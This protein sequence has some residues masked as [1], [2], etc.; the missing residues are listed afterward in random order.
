MRPRLRCRLGISGLE[1]PGFLPLGHRSI[2]HSARQVQGSEKEVRGGVAGVGRDRALQHRQRP[3]ALREDVGGGHRGRGVEVR[4]AR[5]ATLLAAVAAVVGDLGMGLRRRRAGLGDDRGPA[6][7]VAG[8]ELHRVVPGAQVHVVDGRLDHPLGIAGEVGPKSVVRV[9]ERDGLVA[10]GRQRGVFLSPMGE[11]LSRFLAAAEA[12]QEDDLEG[13]GADVARLLAE[14]GANPCQGGLEVTSGREPS[15]DLEQGRR[16]RP[17]GAKGALEVGARPPSLAPAAPGD[18]KRILD[19]GVVRDASL[20]LGEAHGGLVVT[21]QRDGQAAGGLVQENALRKPSAERP[22][23]CRGR[24]A[25]CLPAP[26]HP[27]GSP[28]RPRSAPP[29]FATRGAAC[30]PTSTSPAGTWS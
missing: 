23:R 20:R 13:A 18:A 28:S 12:P 15:P 4:S 9:A 29:G 26:E 1:S 8:Q 27:R 7:V 17:L 2:G 3:G 6:R 21:L 10:K 22:G 19:V 11:A 24:G 5:V 16:A 30:A 14:G 25:A